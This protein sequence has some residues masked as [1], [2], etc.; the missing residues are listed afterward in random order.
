MGFYQ[1]FLMECARVK[2]SPSA[3]AA[4]CG[5]SPAAINGWKN[6]SVPSDANLARVASFFGISPESLLGDSKDSKDGELEEY[7]EMLRDRPEMKTML[8]TM[9]GAT[10]EQAQQAVSIVEALIKS[11]KGE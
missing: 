7:L 6:G 3:V 4:E 2:K 8:K 9:R 5:L 10:K 11:Q 1:N